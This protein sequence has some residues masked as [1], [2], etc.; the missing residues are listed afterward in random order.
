MIQERLSS[1]FEQSGLSSKG[2]RVAIVL[3]D[4]DDGN[5]SLVVCGHYSCGCG[6]GI[7]FDD[8]VHGGC[9]CDG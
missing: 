2:S 6:C 8:D 9:V 4:G 7:M 3:C 1:C 5:S